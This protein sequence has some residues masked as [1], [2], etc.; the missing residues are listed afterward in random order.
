MTIYLD[1]VF[2]ENICMNSIILFATG[3]VTKTKCKIIRN[4]ISSTIGAVYVIGAYIT[5]NELY[6]NSII[7]I[8]LSITMVYI[9]FYPNNIKSAFKYI[10]IFYLTSFVFGGCAFALLYYIKP[11]NIFY[12]NSG[13][14]SGTYPIK[15]AF[16]GAMIGLIILSI[17]FKLIKNRLK[18]SEMFCNVEI[19]YNEKITKIRAIIDSGN[20]LKDPITGSSVIVVERK[21][22]VEMIDNKILDNLENIISGEYEIIDEEYISKFRL[23]PFSSLGKQNGMLLGFKP[24]VLRIDF[25]D[26]QRK[27]DKVIIAIYDKDITKNDEYSGIV[28]LEILEGRS[29]INYE[30]TKNIKA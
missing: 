26:A 10:V 9:A 2:I 19:E 24:D 21:K 14:L 13:L 22:L 20:L 15:I 23:I 27:I 4:L 11:Q 16:L 25:D 28:G 18:K 29:E 3:L 1:V 17:S 8:G 30:Y 6:T 7:K 12:N 5:N